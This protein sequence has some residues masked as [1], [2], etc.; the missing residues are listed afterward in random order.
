MQRLTDSSKM[1][2]TNLETILDKTYEEL[3]EFK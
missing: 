2:I 1:K 3:N